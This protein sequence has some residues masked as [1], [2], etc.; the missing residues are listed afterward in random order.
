MPKMLSVITA[1]PTR[2]MVG[3][4]VA[5]SSIGAST[6][7]AAGIG[8][9]ATDVKGQLQG[10]GDLVVAGAFL[11]GLVLMGAGLVRLKAA[12]D[13]GGV[14]VKYS[15]GLW[16]LGVGGGLVALPAITGVG[17]DTIFGEGGGEAASIGDIDI[18]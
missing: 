2:L 12:A 1:F 16:R 3:V 7:N 11:G 6:A 17:A 5:I 15:E 10:I 18:D 8:D 4:A 9:V 14:Q 13:A